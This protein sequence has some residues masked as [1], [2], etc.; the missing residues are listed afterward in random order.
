MTCIDKW[1]IKKI[2]CIPQGLVQSTR[3]FD[4]DGV[5]IVRRGPE[6]EQSR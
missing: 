2:V 3:R 4:S 1:P 5:I 6:S